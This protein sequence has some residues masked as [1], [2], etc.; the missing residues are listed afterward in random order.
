[1]EKA[2]NGRDIKD[3][4]FF[5]GLEKAPDDF[6]IIWIHNSHP[7]NGSELAEKAKEF[8]I[9]EGEKFA[10]GPQPGHSRHSALLLG[11]T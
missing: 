1:M 11:R 3:F 4:P 2:L 6:E 5:W 10:Y 9:P 8:E 7:E